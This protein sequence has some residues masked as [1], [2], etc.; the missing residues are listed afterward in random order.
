M[1]FDKARSALI[2]KAREAKGKLFEQ[3]ESG[4]RD[5]CAQTLYL[6]DY[7]ENLAAAD[8]LLCIENT[9]SKHSSVNESKGSLTEALETAKRFCEAQAK[10]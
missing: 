10:K 5:W 7:Q 1:G 6:K 2:A 3:L 9:L 8:V 4:G